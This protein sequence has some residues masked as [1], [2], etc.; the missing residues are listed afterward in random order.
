MSGRV[1]QIY[2]WTHDQW[3]E[4]QWPGWIEMLTAGGHAPF[5]WRMEWRTA[6][7]KLSRVYGVMVVYASNGHIVLIRD[8]AGIAFR[9]SLD[10]AETEMKRLVE[11]ANSFKK[12]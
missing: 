3:P 8:C 2:D 11:L 10:R 5:P 1:F 6:N 9:A 4:D 12:G 7:Q